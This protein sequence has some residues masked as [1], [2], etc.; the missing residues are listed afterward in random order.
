M[1]RLFKHGYEHMWWDNLMISIFGDDSE[2]EEV[3]EED[4]TDAKTE[5]KQM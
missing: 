1:P 4:D 5:M 2:E 3:V